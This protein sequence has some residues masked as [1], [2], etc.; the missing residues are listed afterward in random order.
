MDVSETLCSRE[1]VYGSFRE[2]SKRAGAIKAAMR[3]G[4]N[5]E[6]LPDPI[7]ES[8]EMIATKIARILTG[9]CHHKDSWHD[10]AGYAT[11]VEQYIS[12]VFE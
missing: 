2:C 10:I 9:E 5:W 4:T 8:L 3:E 6:E 12:E 1:N 7:R 11:L